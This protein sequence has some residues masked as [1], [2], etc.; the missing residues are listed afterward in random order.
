MEELMKMEEN[1]EESPLSENDAKDSDG[2][3]A[4]EKDD[5][6][7]DDDDDEVPWIKM[8]C[9][10]KGNEFF[11]EIDDGYAQDNF[12]LFGIDELDIKY[13]EVAYDMILDIENP[14][15]EN[16]T[17]EESQEVESSSESLYGA[18]HSR[19]I[20]TPEGLE[21]MKQ[22]YLNGDFGVCPRVL[23]KGEK[24][25]PT[26]SSDCLRESTL[27]IYC[28][29]CKQ[30]YFPRKIE[31]RGIDGAY[32]GTTFA[33]LFFMSYPDLLPKESPVPYVAKVYGF[34]YRR[35]PRKKKKSKSDQNNNNNE[36]NNNNEKE[37]TI[38]KSPTT[39]QYSSTTSQN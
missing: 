9:G 1:S 22:K 23:C 19:F 17:D 16:C 21:K 6:Q 38:V 29:K 39:A 24:V 15:L 25:V 27:K 10:L 31:H 7:D 2:F 18:I 4:D 26:G 37:R 33:G 34:K 14:M 13:Y 8:F 28:P 20:L 32:W 3:S 30:C 35:P 5:I 11:C 36:E 12:N